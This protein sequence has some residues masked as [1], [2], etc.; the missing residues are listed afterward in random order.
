MPHQ[1]TLKTHFRTW[2]RA[3]FSVVALLS[4]LPFATG[5][6]GVS[7][8]ADPNI[9]GKCWDYKLVPN[10][11]VEPTLDSTSVFVPD[12]DNRLH[13]IDLPTGNKI[14]SSEFG[15]D[16]ISNL[17]VVHDSIVFATSL[18]TGTSNS[19]GRSVIRAISR[20]TGI[21]L[22]Q[23]D[24]TTTEH[25][26]LGVVNGNVIAVGSRGWASSF[27]ASDG[28]LAWSSDLGSGVLADPLF[29]DTEIKIGTKNNEV[30]SLDGSS[31]KPR[32]VWK[33]DY[34]PS[35]ILNDSAGRL[36]V[37]DDRGNLT[38]VSADGDRLWR[39]RNG[40]QISS[41]QEY[42]SEYVAASYDNFIY[43]LSRGGNVEWKRRL[44]GRVSGRLLIIGNTAVISIVGTGSV[45]ALNLKNGKILNRIESGEEVSLTVSANRD[46]TGFVAAG[47][48][49]LSYYGSKCPA[50]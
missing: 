5:A 34:S 23:A 18:Q 36:L 43:K 41:V 14:W 48:L 44:P 16:V 12:I 9:F 26:W 45:Y 21:T 46:A 37:G 39:F 10:L 6:A 33:S 4:L 40:A 42:D 17:L 50:K 19:S 11:S 2:L 27:A 15:G 8:T 30:V 47:P 25:L 29:R 13:A 22:W 3:L 38:A 20:H 32:K 35:A 28:K 49:G 31:G 24:V 1:T 7:D